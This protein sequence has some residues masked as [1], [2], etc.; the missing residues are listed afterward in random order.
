MKK[1]IQFCMDEFILHAIFDVAK[2]STKKKKKK[3]KK[4]REDDQQQQHQH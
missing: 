3:K 4:L 1:Y 2:S